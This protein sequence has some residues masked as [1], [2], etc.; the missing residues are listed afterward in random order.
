MAKVF[1][2]PQKEFVKVIPR[3]SSMLVESWIFKLYT[4]SVKNNLELREEKKKMNMDGVKSLGQRVRA[5]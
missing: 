2:R 1:R 4:H 5:P 3:K